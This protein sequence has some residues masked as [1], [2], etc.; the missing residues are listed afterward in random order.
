MRRA[1]RAP[2]RV[3]ENRWV[4]VRTVMVVELWGGII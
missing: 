3:D 2:R 1:S 4:N